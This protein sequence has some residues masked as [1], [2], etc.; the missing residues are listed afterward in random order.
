MATPATTTRRASGAWA[1]FWSAVRR[2]VAWFTSRDYRPLFARLPLPMLALAASYGVYRFAL[3]FVPAWVAVVQAA[4]FEL[5]YIGLASQANLSEGARGRATAISIGAVVVS[6]VYNALAGLFDRNPEWLANLSAPYEWGMAVLHGAPLAVVAYLV[7]DLLLHADGADLSEVVAQL[8]ADIARMT[9]QAAQYVADLA[10]RDTTIEQL[11][12]AAAQGTQSAAQY[13]VT[14]AQLETKAAQESSA[15]AQTI[16]KLQADLA[17]AVE[18]AKHWKSQAAQKP[19]PTVAAL[20]DYAR[21]QIAS[22]KGSRI[23]ADE[24]GMKDAT[25]RDWLSK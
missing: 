9:A 7:A 4:A 18:A 25:L 2:L 10:Q 19:A 11:Q 21:A 24:I 8:R 17:Q 1:G 15:T 16:S 12:A 14:I 6:I 23:V 13:Q 5:T 20:L 3:L 22:G